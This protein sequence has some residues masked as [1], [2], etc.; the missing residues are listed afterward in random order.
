MERIGRKNTNRIIRMQPGVLLVK[1]VPRIAGNR[2]T[3]FRYGPEF[4][5]AHDNNGM[6][7]RYFDF[8]G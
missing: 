5:Y 3:I 4:R 8:S 7:F 1:R 2:G 6:S